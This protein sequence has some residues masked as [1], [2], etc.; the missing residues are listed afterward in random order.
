[1]SNDDRTEALHHEVLDLG[2]RAAAFG[3]P[4]LVDAAVKISEEAETDDD[5]IGFL[6]TAVE[7][8]A[9]YVEEAIAGR[10]LHD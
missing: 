3:L 10:T 1:M 9:L 5:P 6:S 2:D 8:L 4:D 7:I